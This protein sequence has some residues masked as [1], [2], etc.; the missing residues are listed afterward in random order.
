MGTSNT[1]ICFKFSKEEL[2]HFLSMLSCT[3]VFRKTLLILSVLNSRDTKKTN[4]KN[5]AHLFRQGN[6]VGGAFFV[7]ETAS[8]PRVKLSNMK[9]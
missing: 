6:P 7:E 2:S 3:L 8:S 5:K 1:Y 9:F 4:F